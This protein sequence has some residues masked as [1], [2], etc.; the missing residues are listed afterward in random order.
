MT[1]LN[2]FPHLATIQRQSAGTVDGIGDISVSWSD[3]SSSVAAWFQP[4]SVS[5]RGE[6]NTKYGQV[7]HRIYLTED[8]GIAD[9][10]TRILWVDNNNKDMVIRGAR[11]VT[12]GLGKAFVVMADEDKTDLEND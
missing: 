4:I 2:N 6:L 3:V 10:V 11:D 8:P 5:E 9:D 7:T 1:L 12:A